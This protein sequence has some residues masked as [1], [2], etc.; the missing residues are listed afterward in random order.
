MRC[1]IHSEQEAFGMCKNCFKAV[2]AECAIDCGNGLACSKECEEEV[3][4]YNDMMEKSKQIYG[5]KGKRI[6]LVTMML[7]TMGTIFSLLGLYGMED[8][9]GIFFFAMGLIFLVLAFI[10]WNRQRKMGVST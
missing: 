8:E 3:K 10:S 9:A 2:C 4:D 5:L 6:A 7:G 1:F